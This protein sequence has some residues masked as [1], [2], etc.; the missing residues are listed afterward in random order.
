MGSGVVTLNKTLYGLHQAPRAWYATYPTIFWRMDLDEALLTA[1]S[2]SRNIM[3]IFCWCRS[4]DDIPWSSDG[5]D[6]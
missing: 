2:S 6:G 3:E 4:G 1:P 5:P